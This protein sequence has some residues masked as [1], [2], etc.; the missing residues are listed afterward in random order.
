MQDGVSPQIGS[1]RRKAHESN[2]DDKLIGPT[3]VQPQMWLSHASSLAMLPRGSGAVT[4]LM[5]LPNLLTRCHQSFRCS[6][7]Y[8]PDRPAALNISRELAACNASASEKEART[9]LA[10][11]AA[12]R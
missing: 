11:A 12:V 2:V 4:L 8:F 9:E 3:V 5:V 10:Q 1:G 6:D 7:S